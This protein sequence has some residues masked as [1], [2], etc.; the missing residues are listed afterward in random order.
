VC[1]CV[2][3]VGYVCVSSGQHDF[4]LLRS[5][6][7]PNGSILRCVC[8]CV[9]GWLGVCV[10]LGQHDFDLLRSLVLPDGSILRCVCVWLG[11][12]VCHQGSM[13]LIC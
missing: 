5:L 3:V 12:C 9:V 4:D 10:S 11:M 8:V 1:V 6:V 2:C 7:L 13:T